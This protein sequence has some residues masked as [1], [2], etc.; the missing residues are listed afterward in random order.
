MR[1]VFKDNGEFKSL[2]INHEEGSQFIGSHMDILFKNWNAEK[3]DEKL[4]RFMEYYKL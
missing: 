2:K 4:L 1:K 3:Q